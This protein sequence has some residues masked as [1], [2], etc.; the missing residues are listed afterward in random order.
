MEKDMIEIVNT[1]GTTEQVEVVTYLVSNDNSK[2]YMVYTKGEKQGEEEDQVIYISKI[3]SDDGAFKLEEIVD[4]S[5]W[6]DVQHLLKK[7]ANASKT[8]E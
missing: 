5:E 1:N 4:D 2:K 3:I 7:I 8:D 6:S